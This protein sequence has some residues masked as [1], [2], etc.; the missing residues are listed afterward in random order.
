MATVGD[1]GER[2]FIH[3]L[4]EELGLAM[5]GDD[6]A[7]LPPIPS[8]AVTVDSYFEGVH[9]QRWW[10]GPERL[11]RR[12]L[13]AT[14][15][16]LAATGAEPLWILAAVS[17]PANT[18]VDWLLGLYRG[19]A[20]RPDTAIAGGE[21][22][23]GDRLG[24]TLTGVGNL[25]GQP[26]KR[27]SALPGQRLWVT[28]P[29]GRTLDSPALLERSRS[30][31][32]THQEMRQVNLF[33]DPRA[34]F[35]AARQILAA[36]CRCAIDISDGLASEAEHIAAASRVML[37][38]DTDAVPLVEYAAGRP[39]EAFRAGEDYELLFTAPSGLSFE[40]CHPI[41]RVLEGKGAFLCGPGGSVE[42]LGEG[43]DHF[44]G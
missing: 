27:S 9:F 44:R 42:A 40:G 21:T 23:R 31:S 28:G 30:E 8:P 2:G 5:A 29:L 1:I 18:D 19:L 26:L 33:L 17:L 38:I 36:G 24:I 3:R 39:R 35:D 6:A 41:G 22:V 4:I 12:L 14:L 32:L 37:Q 11:G 10:C 25:P 20:G 16:D 34:R 7:L 15:S 43:Y 13:E